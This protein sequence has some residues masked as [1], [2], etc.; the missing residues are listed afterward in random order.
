[1][2]PLSWD[3][4]TRYTC[5]YKN[6]VINVMFLDQKSLGIKFLDLEVVLD[7]NL[8]IILPFTWN[9][10]AFQG[11]VSWKMWATY[12]IISLPRCFSKHAKSVQKDGHVYDLLSLAILCEPV[13]IE[14]TP[15]CITYYHAPPPPYRNYFMPFWIILKPE[16]WCHSGG[17][18]HSVYCAFQQH[19]SISW[20]FYNKGAWE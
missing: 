4:L 16:I 2:S 13:V 14:K 5:L 15:N 6:F 8:I 7:H 11:F 12:F 17:L 9:F 1:M 10:V 20:C 18:C 3:S 19:C